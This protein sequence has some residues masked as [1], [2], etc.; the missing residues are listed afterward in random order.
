[1]VNNLLVVISVVA[2]VV[3]TIAALIKIL[4]YLH[5]GERSTIRFPR[6]QKVPVDIV[7]QYRRSLGPDRH[8]TSKA[9]CNYLLDKKRDDFGNAIIAEYDLVEFGPVKL[10]VPKRK[11][12]FP[13]LE[14]LATAQ[15]AAKSWRTSC[16]LIMITS[17]TLDYGY[18]SA[19]G[20]FTRIHRWLFLFRDVSCIFLLVTIDSGPI[21]TSMHEWTIKETDS[22]DL[23]PITGWVTDAAD[24]AERAR[25][26]GLLPKNSGFTLRVWEV[27]GK[28]ITAWN[29]VSQCGLN[30]FSAEDNNMVLDA[31]THS[32]GGYAHAFKY[33]EGHELE[34]MTLQMRHS[35]E[36]YLDKFTINDY[37]DWQYTVEKDFRNG[38]EI[39]HVFP[40]RTTY[41]YYDDPIL[42]FSGIPVRARSIIPGPGKLV[43]EANLIEIG[44]NS[45]RVHERHYGEDGKEIYEGVLTI[46]TGGG[47]RLNRELSRGT[48][49]KAFFY[50]WP[51]RR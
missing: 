24:A 34:T 6:M 48:Y 46:D 31:C 23:F 38:Q 51:N 22:K 32:R 7:A 8:E 47:F 35:K 11:G 49:T 19:Q 1:M 21:V 10:A 5:T 37:D 4:E 29:V 15:Q 13:A 33:P 40:A 28:K 50:F 2:G 18:S 25:L 12:A 16:D 36:H 41:F 3:G 30:L 20:I 14:A 27:M 17:G 39:A 43:A 9:V 45:M 44:N 26:H 42:E